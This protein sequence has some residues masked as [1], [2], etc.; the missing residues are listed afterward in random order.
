[1]GLAGGFGAVGIGMAPVTV[2]G[3]VAGAAAYG[4][5]KA[6]GEGDTAAFGAIG[7]GALGGAGVSATVGGMGLAG[8]FGAA[9]IGMGTMTAAGGVV[10]L[11]V[12]GLY[13]AFKQE[14]GQ[15]MAGAI[16][17][18][19]R[20]ESKVLEMEA[21]TEYTQALLELELEA[22]ERKLLGDPVEQNFAALEMEQELE[23]LKANVKAASSSSFNP[24]INS[25]VKAENF[26]SHS[27]PQESQFTAPE[28]KAEA[29]AIEVEPPQSWKCVKVLKGHKASVNSIAISPDGQTLASGSDDRTVNLWNLKTGKQIFTFFGQAGEVHAVAISPDG[30]MLVTGGFD[31]KITSWQLNTKALFRSFFYQN[32]FYSHSGFISSL[33]FSQDRKILASASGDKSIRLWGGYTG[34]IKRTLNGH[35]DTVLSI[36]IT[37]DGQIASGSA[38][39]T[40]R[41]WSLSGCQQPRVLTGHSGW[42]TSV[43]ITPDGNTLASGSTDGTINL[44]NLQTGELLYTLTGHSSGVYSITISPNG[45]TLASGST[46]ELKLWN[47]HS[48]DDG[49]VQGSLLHTLAGCSPVA[50]T[51]DGKTLVSGGEGG[52]IKIWCQVLNSNDF[53][54]DPSLP[55]EWWEVLGVGMDA[56]S[57][58][59]KLAYHHLARQYHPDINRSASAI[60]KMQAIN[61]AYEEFLKEFSAFRVR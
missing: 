39:K 4:A 56:D 16:D 59:V 31:N 26:T 18:F 14:P 30:Q 22:L 12:Y 33:A 60:A 1:M 41:L 49:T 5:F 7:L 38:D 8:G 2:A 52:R 27:T 35:L 34:E 3:A 21:H 57:E 25:P 58:A 37:S 28:I 36:A 54:L 47:L 6:I 24:T 20:M 10:G 44:W 45:R 9:G 13:K 43:V 53:T 17:A 19:E 55:G 51:P 61:T 46:K 40:I 42:V 11:G 15:R 23:A 32:S 29:L 48:V 50:F